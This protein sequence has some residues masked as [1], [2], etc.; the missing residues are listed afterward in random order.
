VP[1]K[2]VPVIVTATLPDVG[3]VAGAIPVMV[4]DDRAVNALP[5][6]ATPPT[7]TTTLPVV[8]PAG[9]GTVMLVFDHA[10]GVPAVPLNVTVLVPGAEPKLNPVMMTDVPTA[11]DVSDRLVMFGAVARGTS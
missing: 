8:A 1:M 4:G 10:V 6:L 11:A 2:L 3:N 7:V 5:L 9:T